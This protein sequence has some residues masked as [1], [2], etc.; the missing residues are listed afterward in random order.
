[1]LTGENPIEREIENII[2]SDDYAR[3]RKGDKNKPGNYRNFGRRELWIKR[4]IRIYQ[5]QFRFVPVGPK[6]GS[7]TINSFSRNSSFVSHYSELLI[8]VMSH[9]GASCR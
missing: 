3:K 2:R 1:L 6:K 5:L 8:T 9:N 4:V 7:V